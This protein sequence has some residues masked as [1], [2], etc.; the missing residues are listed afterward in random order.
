[1][2]LDL[3]KP[4]G[5][6]VLKH[7]ARHSDVCL[8]NVRPGVAEKLG[9]AYG[10]LKAA[11]EDLVYLSISGYGPTG[12]Y[13]DA[14]VYDFIIQAQSGVGEIM[15]DE[16]GGPTQFHNLL[17][18]KVTALNAS[19]AITA[20]LLAVSRGRGG[21]HMIELSM[22]DSA[23]H[24]LFPDGKW[25]Q[26]WVDS[27]QIPVEWRDGHAKT[28]YNCSDGKVAIT[29]AWDQFVDTHD[30]PGT[31]LRAFLLDLGIEVDQITDEIKT[32]GSVSTSSGVT[33]EERWSSRRLQGADALVRRS[34]HELARRYLRSA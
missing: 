31:R 30:P 7:M 25:N 33:Y 16:E 4:E 24:F 10:D 34:Q 26:V 2:A 27:S 23:I 19:Q 18:D 28:E 5:V 21:Q 17:M 22:I 8:Q 3:R 1:M 20:A 6:A 29:Y 13:V 14:K 11:N 9:I 15:R 12:P 32:E